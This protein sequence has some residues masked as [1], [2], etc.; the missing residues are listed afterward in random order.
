M[1]VVQAILSQSSP[2]MSRRSINTLSV[3]MAYSSRSK[4]KANKDGSLARFTYRPETSSDVQPVGSPDE[5]L[6]TVS[7]RASRQSWEQL[8]QKMYEIDPMYMDARMSAMPGGR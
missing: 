2:S 8:I 6:E 3:I 5:Y 7:S 1:P 4:G